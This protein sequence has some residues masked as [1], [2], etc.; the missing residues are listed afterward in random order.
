MH[1][2]IGF[3]IV[4]HLVVLYTNIHQKIKSNFEGMEN[5]KKAKI[6]IIKVHD[7]TTEKFSIDKIELLNS[8]LSYLKM[9]PKKELI[10]LEKNKEPVMQRTDMI[11]NFPKQTATL[12][13]PPSYLAPVYSSQKLGRERSRDETEVKKG[14]NVNLITTRAVSTDSNLYKIKDDIGKKVGNG[15]DSEDKFKQ[16]VQLYRDEVF[17]IVYRKFEKF[18]KNKRLNKNDT[19]ILN[20][21]INQDGKILNIEIKEASRDEKFNKL[22]VDVIKE[23]A[24]F[25]PFPRVLDVEIIKLT[26]PFRIKLP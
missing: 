12:N 1:K 5:T 23:I 10:L 17:T 3:S 22:C 9:E 16:Y 26:I 20:V 2:F 25:P 15:K 11:G 18:T 7:V 8:R 4:L 6:T 13:V 14:S 21:S 19:V 24:K